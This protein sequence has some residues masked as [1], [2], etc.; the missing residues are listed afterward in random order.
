[1]TLSCFLCC[2]DVRLSVKEE[3][4][5][6]AETQTV[7]HQAPGEGLRQE[8]LMSTPSPDTQLCGLLSKRRQRYTPKHD[9][10]SVRPKTTPHCICTDTGNIL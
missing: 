9:K 4:V 10:D 3:T 2:A 8:P 7:P 6:Q 1:M 5:S